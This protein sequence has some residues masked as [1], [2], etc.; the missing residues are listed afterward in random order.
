MIEDAQDMLANICESMKLVKYIQMTILEVWLLY[1]FK[2][3]QPHQLQI[4]YINSEANKI[5]LGRFLVKRFLVNSFFFYLHFS[6]G[7]PVGKRGIA[8]K[9]RLSLRFSLR[10]V[11]I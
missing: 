11:F 10:K 1:L 8:D 5:P 2:V 7:L 6:F 3:L 4:K 9:K